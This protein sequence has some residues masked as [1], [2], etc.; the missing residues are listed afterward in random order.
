MQITATPKANRRKDIFTET[1]SNSVPTIVEDADWSAI[2]PS[3]LPRIPQSVTRP[4]RDEQTKNPLFAIQA[5][6][7][8]KPTSTLTRSGNGF[9]DVAAVEGGYQA[10]SPLQPGRSS[11]QLFNLGPETAVPQSSWSSQGVQETPAKQKSDAMLVHSHPI[12]S[13]PIFGKENMGLKGGAS[14]GLDRAP[15]R[16]AGEDSI[17]KALGWDDADDIDDLA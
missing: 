6:P 1:Q 17:Y 9:L 11:A 15:G 8:R 16:N 2:P 12:L 5:T 7:T 14:C 13:T 10:L 3:S 4:S